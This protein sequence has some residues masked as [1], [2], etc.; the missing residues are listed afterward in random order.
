MAAMVFLVWGMVAYPAR[1]VGVSQTVTPAPLQDVPGVQQ[2][3]APLRQY[4]FPDFGFSFDA[5]EDWRAL[6]KEEQRIVAE[7]SEDAYA[8]GETI[9]AL[10]P[11]IPNGAETAIVMID[12]LRDPMKD[13]VFSA[14]QTMSTVLTGLDWV[15]PGSWTGRKWTRVSTPPFQHEIGGSAAATIGIHIKGDGQ[16]VQDAKLRLTMIELPGEAVSVAGIMAS[17]V[18]RNSEVEAIL[19]SFAVISND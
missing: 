11:D 2:V 16:G 1:D 12:R 18:F 15:S 9:I 19:A 6:T 4:S 14:L 10:I 3:S 17:D 5:P 8:T 7:E 13:E